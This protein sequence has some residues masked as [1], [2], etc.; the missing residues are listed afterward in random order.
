MFHYLITVTHRHPA[1]DNVP[2]QTR[3]TEKLITRLSPLDKA[4]VQKV[5]YTQ[6]KRWPLSINVTVEPIE[7]SD[8]NRRVNSCP[9]KAA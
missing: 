7:E 8:Y 4:G 3:A 9:M 6:Y 5:I 2:E 1:V